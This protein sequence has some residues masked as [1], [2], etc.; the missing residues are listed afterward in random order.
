MKFSTLISFSFALL[1]TPLA[2]TAQQFGDFNYSSDGTNITITGYTGG[3]EM[4]TIPGAIAGLP[5]TR[6]GDG[7]FAY[8]SLSDVLI[9]NS[10]TNIGYEAFAYCYY[11]TQITIPDG[12]ISIGDYAFLECR[13]LR[14]VNI[15]ASVTRI[16]EGAF[17]LFSDRLRRV[18]FQGNAPSLGEYVF[19]SGAEATV[20]YR[21]GTAG[22][23]PTFGGLPAVMWDPAVR[24]TYTTNNN[25]I[26]ITGYIGFDRVVTIPGTING[27]PVTDIGYAAFGGEVLTSLTIPNSVVSI[28]AFAFTGCEH[29]RRCFFQGNAPSLDSFQM[30]QAS[31]V[32]YYLPGTTGWEPTFGELR[33]VLWNPVIQSSGPDFGFGS[34]GFGFNITGTTNIPIVVEATTNLAGANWVALQSLNLTNG[35]FHFSDPAWAN[36][37]ARLYRIRSP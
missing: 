17:V 12:V 5:V 29:L 27:L 15:P 25:R 33:T 6:I 22:W 9:P 7:A 35:S 31:F 28:S 20:Y 14:I 34:A 21:A 26:T 16:G 24:F 10:V 18:Y 30:I 8:S 19:D 1:L 13:R 32:V 4:V 11:L 37:P 3:E 23:G 36:Y 2:L